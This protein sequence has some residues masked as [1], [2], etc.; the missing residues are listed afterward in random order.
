MGTRDETE[1]KGIWACERQVRCGEVTRKCISKGYLVKF[2]TE[3][4]LSGLSLDWKGGG[5]HLYKRA[6]SLSQGNAMKC[7]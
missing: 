2:D 7:F 4:V 5:G 3:R 1:R 6:F